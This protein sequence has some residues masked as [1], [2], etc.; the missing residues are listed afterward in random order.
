MAALVRTLVKKFVALYVR[1]SRDDGDEGDS[2]SIQ[3][4][5]DILEKYVRDHGITNYKIYKDDGYSG[6]N[7]VE[8]R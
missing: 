4:Q 8:V 1:L 5:I 7:F 6:T 2:N 3:H